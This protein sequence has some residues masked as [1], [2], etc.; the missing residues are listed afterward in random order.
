VLREVLSA[1]GARG[2]GAAEMA[3]GVCRGEQVAG[4]VAELAGKL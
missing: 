1:V 4:L 2:G 3:Q